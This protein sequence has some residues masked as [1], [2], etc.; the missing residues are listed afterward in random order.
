[1]RI[2]I[3]ILLLFWFS[4]CSEKIKENS[5]DPFDYIS[6]TTLIPIDRATEPFTRAQQF[7]DGNLYWW[8]SNRGTIS[9]F[10]IHSKKQTS[11]IKLSEEG[12]NGLGKPLG[13]Y[14]LNSNSIYIPSMSYDINLIN[15][16]SEK[17]AT[18]DYKNLSKLGVI[19]ASMSRYSNLFQADELGDLYFLMRDLQNISP[20]EL[21]EKALQDH[22]PILSFDKQKQVFK[23]LEYRVTPSL[24]KFENSIDFG[25]SSSKKSMLLLHYQSN[26]L[27]EV[28][29]NG[30]DY[31]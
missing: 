28:D 2:V 29:F 23:Y 15:S 21:N 25:I 5:K 8:N 9:V 11:T 1:M 22:P 26:T 27:F 17:I 16:Q 4:T 7:L 20:S 18:Y 30:L 13:F 19:T 24:L 3:P 12:P 6:D 31:K 10:D 14:V